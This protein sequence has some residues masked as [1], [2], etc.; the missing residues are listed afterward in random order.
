MLPAWILWATV[1]MLVALVQEDD[2]N[3]GQFIHIASESFCGRGLRGKPLFL[4]KKDSNNKRQKKQL[5]S[6]K[7]SKTTPWKFSASLKR[8]LKKEAKDRCFPSN[9]YFT[10]VSKLFRFS[11]CLPGLQVGYEYEEEVIYHTGRTWEE[12]MEKKRKV[13]QNLH[14]NGLNLPPQTRML[15]PKSGWLDVCICISCFDF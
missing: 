10:R 12:K 7:L 5:P 11:F 2:D 15:A 14:G 8:P 6:F 13:T 1:C 3:G 9:H 4:F